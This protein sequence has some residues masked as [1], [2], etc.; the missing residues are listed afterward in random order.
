MRQPRERYAV[1]FAAAALL[2]C[3]VLLTTSS[4]KLRSRGVVLDQLN[5]QTQVQVQTQTQVEWPQQPSQEQQEQQ[6]QEQGQQ[7]YQQ[8]Y[9]DIELMHAPWYQRYMGKTVPATKWRTN[10]LS[11]SFTPD[12]TSRRTKFAYYQWLRAR[13][14]AQDNTVA[15]TQS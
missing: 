1:C 15:E 11:E 13:R 3:A 9:N 14:A 5:Q 4:S 12:G 10:G 7:Q 6:D 8:S 2:C